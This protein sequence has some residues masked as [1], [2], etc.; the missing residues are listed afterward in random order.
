[1]KFTPSDM[2]WRLTYSIALDEIERLTRE[3]AQ[4]KSQHGDS[5]E[6]QEAE[7]RGYIRG[8]GERERLRAAL[9]PFSC[10][11]LRV[12]SDHYKD[13]NW[14]TLNFTV[15]DLRA[16]ARANEHKTTEKE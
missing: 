4:I 13:S 5:I 11:G 7:Q 6:L 14:R 15:G 16:A 9:K 10:E 2:D 1:M 3:I 8:E 12:M